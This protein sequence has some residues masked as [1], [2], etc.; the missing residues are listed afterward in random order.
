MHVTTYVAVR[1]CPKMLT[2]CNSEA[3]W[4]LRIYEPRDDLSQSGTLTCLSSVC[5]CMMESGGHRWQTVP[6]AKVGSIDIPVL[7]T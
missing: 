3:G 7:K 5:L 4:W 6:L 1:T 2:E